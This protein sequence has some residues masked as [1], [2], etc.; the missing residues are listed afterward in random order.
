M[1]HH[2]VEELVPNVIYDSIAYPRHVVSVAV[3][4]EASDCH[5]Y[6]NGETNPDDGIDP[7]T[8]I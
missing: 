7:G 1:P 5:H 3:R 6:R 8:N 4:A 2:F